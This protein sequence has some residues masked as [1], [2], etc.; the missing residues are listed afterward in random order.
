MKE[1]SMPIMTDKHL[2]PLRRKILALSGA[3]RNLNKLNDKYSCRV[4]EAN[5]ES[6][7]IQMRCNSGKSAYNLRL[8]YAAGEA[9]QYE[10]NTLRGYLFKRESLYTG[11]S[12]Q[13]VSKEMVR[14]EVDNVTYTGFDVFTEGFSFEHL[15]LNYKVN[16]AGGTVDVTLIVNS[17]G[18]KVIETTSNA[19]NVPLTGGFVTSTDGGSTITPV[20]IHGNVMMFTIGDTN[21][22]TFEKSEVVGN[23]AIK[24]IDFV[25]VL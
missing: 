17:S 4:T 20:C 3:V 1:K 9:R 19:N 12:V 11:A 18:F 5:T 6:K 22:A 10:I 13:I 14:L 21:K 23:T 15:V 7:Y 8:H 24:T 2:K 16:F 25:G